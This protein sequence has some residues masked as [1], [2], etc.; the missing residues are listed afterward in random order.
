MALG[1][2]LLAGFFAFGAVMSGL[3]AVMLLRSG[4]AL[5]SLWR[6]N[7]AAREQLGSL[8]WAGIGLMAVVSLGCGIAAAGLWGG[9]PWG[10]RVAIVLLAINLAGDTLN[11]LL[12]RDPRTLIGLPIGGGFILYLLSARVRR[13]FSGSVTAGAVSGDSPAGK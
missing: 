4:T 10:R 2:W 7:P 6:L 8:G 5:E 3:A 13:T 11:A 12:R 9:R 1:V